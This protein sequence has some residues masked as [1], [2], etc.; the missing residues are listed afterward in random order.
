MLT[1]AQITAILGLL[2]AFGADPSTVKNVEVILTH[3][4]AAMVQSANIKTMDTNTDPI[5]GQ[6]VEGKDVYKGPTTSYIFD[7][8]GCKWSVRKTPESYT[9]GQKMIWCPAAE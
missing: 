2:L 3:Q 5:V 6:N 4:P 7:D 8:K 9:Q 1:I